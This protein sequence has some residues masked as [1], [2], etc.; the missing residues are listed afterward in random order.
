VQ[1][2]VALAAALFCV[3]DGQIGVYRAVIKRLSSRTSAHAGVAIPFKFADSSLKSMGI[4]TPFCGMARNDVN[5][6]TA[7]N[8]AIN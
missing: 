6:R 8:G 3:I 4:A 5:F 7:S 1:W 2:A